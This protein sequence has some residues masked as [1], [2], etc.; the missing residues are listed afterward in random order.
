MSQPSI[1]Q[2]VHDLEING[3]IAWPFE[4]RLLIYYGCPLD[5][6]RWNEALVSSFAEAERWL[7]T[8]FPECGPYDGS[9]S[10]A[11]VDRLYR[12]GVAAGIYWVYDSAFSVGVGVPNELGNVRPQASASSWAEAEQWLA[13]A[14]VST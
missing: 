9:G 13:S 12:G 6:K 4:S 11:I 10:D 14:L 7:V 3:G 5:G 1:I 8:Q 2:C